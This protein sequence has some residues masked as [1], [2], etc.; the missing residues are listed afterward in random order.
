[1]FAAAANV[2]VRRRRGMLRFAGHVAPAIAVAI[3]RAASQSIIPAHRCVGAK[4]T[5]P[6]IPGTVRDGTS[7]R[8][9]LWLRSFHEND[10]YCVASSNARLDN[11]VSIPRAIV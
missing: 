5:S 9:T 7:H 8:H 11:S 1:M 3:P 6:K 10:P 4:M 2:V